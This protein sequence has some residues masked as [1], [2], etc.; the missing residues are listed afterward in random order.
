MPIKILPND[1]IN[2]IAAGEVVDR[3]A[4][5]VKELVENS[6]DAGASQIIV[7]IQN[8]GID[9]I[10]ITDNGCGMNKEDLQMSIVRH[11]TS[12]IQTLD[13]LSHI[14]SF[15]FRGEALASIASVSNLKIESRQQNSLAGIAL[16]REGEDDETT[17]QEIGCP[18]G[19]KVKISNIFFNI[20]ARRKF[21][22]NS[23]TEFKYILDIMTNFAIIHPQIAWRLV[24]NSR[25]VFDYYKKENWQDRVKEVLGSDNFKEL[26]YFDFEIGEMDLKGFV[27]VPTAT[28]STRDHQYLFVNNR[29]VYNNIISKAI[30]EG[31]A[32]QIPRSA[33]PMYVIKIELEP[34]MVDVNVHP[35]KTE[36]K[37]QNSQAVFRSVMSA[38][39]NTIEKQEEGIR[40]KEQTQSLCH[41]EFISGSHGSMRKNE[42]PGQARND[43][44]FHK[45]LDSRPLRRIEASLRGNDNHTFHQALEFN[46]QIFQTEASQETSAPKN[47]KILGQAKHCYIVVEKNSGILFIDQHAVHERILY[48]ELTANISKENYKG[49]QLLIPLKLELQTAE[50]EIVRN[51]LEILRKLGFDIEEFGFNSLLVN[52]IPSILEKQDNIETAVKNIISDIKEENSAT[53]T[54]EEKQKKILAYTACRGAIKAGDRINYAMQERLAEAVLENKVKPTCPH[55]RPVCFELDWNEIEKRCKRK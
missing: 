36:V 43:N 37:F 21:L 14:H 39:R 55:G 11:A 45:K 22:K 48:D 12:K 33:N 30:Y 32:G 52:S 28:R 10:Q 9:L 19:T 18:V 1:L 2:K 15:G 53:N 5:V 51:N 27:S 8:G 41:P 17:I 44:Y 35:R 42:I 54:L 20:P 40:K 29:Q 13:D 49:Q 31:Y 47:Y 7:E 26:K 25:A 23:A 6:I 46:R 38:V 4:S 50:I 24:H 34:E 3:P 16:I